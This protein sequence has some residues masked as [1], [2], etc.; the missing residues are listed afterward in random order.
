MAVRI[1]RSQ[2]ERSSPLCRREETP[3]RVHSARRILPQCL[4]LS[5][6]RPSV[7]LG[8]FSS[9]SSVQPVVITR[10]RHKYKRIR[11]GKKRER[12]GNRW[13][14]SGNEAELFMQHLRSTLCS[15]MENRKEAGG[16]AARDSRGID[17]RWDIKISLARVE[18][19]AVSVAARAS[20]FS[21]PLFLALGRAK[22]PIGATGVYFGCYRTGNGEALIR[23]P[24][25]SYLRARTRATTRTEDGRI[26]AVFKETIELYSQLR[27]TATATFT[28]RDTRFCHWPRNFIGERS[29]RLRARVSKLETKS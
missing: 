7:V 19:A 25:S 6:E 26:F 23:I 16:W 29:G 24:M 1:L 9:L 2:E 27:Y 12:A 11:C 21:V 18:V 17:T 22:D 4:L 20:C 8:L 15:R 28:Q 10:A 13:E 3:S 14:R 5:H